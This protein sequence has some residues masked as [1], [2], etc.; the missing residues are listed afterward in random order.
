MNAI[1]IFFKIIGYT[2]WFGA[3][4]WG[5]FLCLAIISKVAGYG[6]IVVALVLGPVTFTAAPFYAGFV[7]D[8][9]FPLILNYGGSIAGITLIGI[10]DAI[11]KE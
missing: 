6:G 5:F 8:D 3:G 7:W 9:W 4:I 11:S 2:I 10:G 1:G